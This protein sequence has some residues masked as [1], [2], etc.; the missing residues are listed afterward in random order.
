VP[1][2]YLVAG[3]PVQQFLMTYEGTKKPTIIAAAEAQTL[4]TVYPIINRRKQ[5]E[6]LL[7]AGSQIVS[8]S[9]EVA[10][11]LGI[12]WN[13]DVTIQMQSANGSLE[14]TDGLAENVPFVFEGITV[15][16]QVHVIKNAAYKVILGRPFDV[17]TESV[18]TNQKEGGQLLTI[19]DPSSGQRKT[20]PT[21]VKG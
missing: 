10:V 3:D 5:V 8:M 17:L 9:R 1:D 4:R 13:P 11:D 14:T 21:H 16:L 15:Y 7:D 19:K 6:S 12:S 20:I 2:G 18:V